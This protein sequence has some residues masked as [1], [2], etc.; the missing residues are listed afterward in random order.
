MKLLFL[1]SLFTIAS[2]SSLGTERSFSEIVKEISGSSN[3]TSFEVGKIK[4]LLD[5]IGFKNCSLERRQ[6]DCQLCLGASSLL[7]WSKYANNVPLNRSQFKGLFPS[8]LF[9]L[10]PIQPGTVGAVCNKSATQQAKNFTQS[11]FKSLLRQ[12]GGVSS[13][14][15]SHVDKLLDDIN[16][17]LNWRLTKKP[18]FDVDD[19][20]KGSGLSESVKN[21]QDLENFSVY[22]ILQLLEGHCIA[23]HGDKKS[24]LP[25]AKEFMDS[26]FKEFGKNGTISLEKFES[27]L[28]K[29]GI[30]NE[31]TSGTSSTGTGHSGH[32]HRKRRSI[33]TDEHSR[34]KRSVPGDSHVNKCFTPENLLSIHSINQKVGLNEAQFKDVCPSLVQQIESGSCKPKTSTVKK[35][36][37]KETGWK[38]WVSAI[39]AVLIIS[40]GSLVGILLAPFSEEKS[41]T[42]ILT[43]LIALAVS[44]LLGDAILHLFPH[45]LNLHKHEEGSSHAEESITGKNSFIWKSL[46]FLLGVYVF[47]LFEL[48]MHSASK[49]KHSHGLEETHQHVGKGRSHSMVSGP[50]EIIHDRQKDG[51]NSL[52]RN[53]LIPTA[54]GMHKCDEKTC[55]E[56][57]AIEAKVKDT[58]EVYVNQKCS[59]GNSRD[60]LKDSSKKNG[61]HEKNENGHAHV[62]TKEGPRWRSVAWMVLMGD[63]IHNF[64]DGVAIGVAFTD[65]FPTGFYGGVST[66]IAILCHELPHELGDFAILI[67]SGLPIKM[68]L[69]LNFLSSLTSVFGALIGVS[70]GQAMDATSW[71]FAL[72]AGLFVYIA[73]A[74]M[75]PEL[76][77]SG[78][79]RHA[80]LKTVIVQNAGLYL[81][82][83]IMI[84]LAIF[85][86]D[87]KL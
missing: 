84:C 2:C 60:N 83:G 5:R 31:T 15:E 36:S 70:L 9:L 44:T 30:G 79:L 78:E 35:T 85:E 43:F 62:V 58:S 6:T 45:S 40:L 57:D 17:T 52:N 76:I 56:L 61:V 10:T 73:L 28:K 64:L 55:I 42:F 7:T 29:L 12:Y 77:H 68:A 33:G 67:Q 80:P 82:F 39:V 21:E 38:P 65:K 13:L 46:V 59:N 1:A 51:D 74:D 86:E 81:G 87:I 26:I 66:S 32:D 22:L 3:T 16:S 4:S 50:V 24:S 72:T 11:A 14:T 37:S 41:F 25:K 8:I 47:Y 34:K 19:A 23:K 75:L 49:H 53:A 69:L 20:F 71:I 18:C 54:S 27:L 63:A 48:Y